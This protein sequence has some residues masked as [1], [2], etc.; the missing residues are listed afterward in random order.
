MIK[1][2]HK[3]IRAV[4]RG[5]SDFWYAFWGGILIILVIGGLIALFVWAQ[6]T[7]DTHAAAKVARCNREEDTLNIIAKNDPQDFPRVLEMFR[8]DCGSA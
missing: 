6:N 8:Y 4:G 3:A 2:I 5:I 1:F 7:D